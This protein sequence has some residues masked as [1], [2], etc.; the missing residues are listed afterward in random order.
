VER[1]RERGEIAPEVDEEM[2][3]D[4]ENGAAYYRVPW[5]GEVITETDAAR[6][7]DV[8]LGGAR[9]PAHP[10]QTGPGPSLRQGKTDTRN[11]LRPPGAHLVR[12]GLQ[13]DS[14]G[15][16]ALQAIRPP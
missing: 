14:T 12:A 10:P 6:L 3:L 2:L 13:D 9:A 5:R 7:V 1:A 16:R 15:G 8:I 11:G 4:M